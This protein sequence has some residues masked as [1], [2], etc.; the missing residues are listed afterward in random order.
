MYDANNQGDRPN[1]TM[2]TPGW[3]LTSIAQLVNTDQDF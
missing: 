2:N 1:M 3:S